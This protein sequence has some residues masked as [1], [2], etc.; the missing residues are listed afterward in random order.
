VTTFKGKP[1]AIWRME[2]GKA[3]FCDN[4]TCHVDQKLKEV[5]SK[6]GILHH[7]KL[8]ELSTIAWHVSDKGNIVGVVGASATK[9]WFNAPQHVTANARKLFST[10]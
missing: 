1:L 8:K 5:I 6:V 7:E 3:I 2:N 9:V 4:S 10:A